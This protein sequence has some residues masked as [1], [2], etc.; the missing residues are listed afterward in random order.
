MDSLRIEEHMLSTAKAD[1]LC[2]KLNCVLCISR[3]ISVC[4]DAKFSEGVSPIHDSLEVS[5]YGCFLSLD[6]TVVDLT[7]C[8][9]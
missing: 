4:A 3:C 9:V 5:A 1:A 6:I 7:C 8:T 2:A